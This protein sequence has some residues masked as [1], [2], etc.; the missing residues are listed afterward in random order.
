MMSLN[1][2]KNYKA[3]LENT[4]TNKAFRSRLMFEAVEDENFSKEILSILKDLKREIS[5]LKLMVLNLMKLK[6]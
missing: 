6:T 3:I 5:S 4:I 2:F 1:Q